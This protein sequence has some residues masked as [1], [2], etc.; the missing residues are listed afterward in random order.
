MA[1]KRFTDSAERTFANVNKDDVIA[2]T[3]IDTIDYKFKLE[4]IAKYA[5][6]E[7]TLPTGVILGTTDPQA[8]TNKSI[9]GST[10]VIRNIGDNEIEADAGIDAR[11]IG[12]GDVT[13]TELSCIKSVTSNVQDQITG[14]FSSIVALGT[15]SR[16]QYLE[17]TTDASS[18]ITI[19]EAQ[20][21]TAAGITGGLEKSLNYYS[22]SVIAK[23][24]SG[25]I[26]HRD[27]TPVSNI[28]TATTHNS[29]VHLDRNILTLGDASTDYILVYTFNVVNASTPGT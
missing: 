25:T 26:V 8:I 10:N 28:W 29:V 5:L 2:G 14:N 21:K 27:E 16:I 19:T 23:R 15:P 4:T 20:I 12:N 13:D 24:Q 11:K 1:T 18:Q 3:G 9:S 6:N 17:I 7:K 22:L